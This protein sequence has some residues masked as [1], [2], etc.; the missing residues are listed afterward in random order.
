MAGRKNVLIFLPKIS[1]LILNA[2]SLSHLQQMTQ[3]TVISLQK[4]FAR[5]DQID[6]ASGILITRVDEIIKDARVDLR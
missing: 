1:Q 6:G 3:M 5:V 4:M 2:V